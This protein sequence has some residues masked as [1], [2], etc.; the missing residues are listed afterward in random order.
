MAQLVAI[1]ES[2][3]EMLFEQWQKQWNQRT[4]KV[5][6]LNIASYIEYP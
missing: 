6:F 3:S 4:V 5:A 2:A 1:L